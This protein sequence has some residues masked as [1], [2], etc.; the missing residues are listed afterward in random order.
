M[1]EAASSRKG[2]ERRDDF[3]PFELVEDDRRDS[4]EASRGDLQTEDDFL[5]PWAGVSLGRFDGVSS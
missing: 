3:L 4:G 5:L 2:P 1:G